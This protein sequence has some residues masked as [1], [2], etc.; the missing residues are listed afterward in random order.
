MEGGGAGGGPGFPPASALRQ[1]YILR[2][3]AV[4]MPANQSQLRLE[5]CSLFVSTDPV[6]ML[7]VLFII[8][9]QEI[10]YLSV[11]ISPQQ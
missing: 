10:K 6:K 7:L 1:K 8:D 3:S 4:M 5:I 11:N 9:D 2:V